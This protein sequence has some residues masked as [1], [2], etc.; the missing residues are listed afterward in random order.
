MI[1]PDIIVIDIE[2]TTTPVTFVTDVL[3]PYARE[4]MAAFITTHAEDPAVRTAL[5]EARAMAGDPAADL[6]KLL[7]HWI[8]EDRK[9]T[10][11]KTLQGLIWEDGY[12]SGAISAPVY[13]DVPDALR[14]WRERGLCLYVYSS[15]SVRAQQLLFGHTNVGD[16]TELFCGNFD[17]RIGTK[18][19]AL[20]YTA[21]AAEIGARPSSILFLTDSPAEV[22]AARGAGWQV[23]RID[24]NLDP[25]AEMLEQG[26]E[27]VAGSFASVDRR[28]RRL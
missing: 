4:R 14:A 12:T 27:L 26:G 23:I 17:T 10:P 6:A 20:S 7:V 22:A 2:G 25:A 5:E 21:I 16:L 13:D 19:D 1:Q 8:D 24:R 18:T 28:L 3:F 15:G 9:I 11:L